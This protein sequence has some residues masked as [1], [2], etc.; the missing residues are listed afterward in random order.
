MNICD[1]VYFADV[2]WLHTTDYLKWIRHF[3]RNLRKVLTEVWKDKKTKENMREI[4]EHEIS[5]TLHWGLGVMPKADNEIYVSIS[6]GK[7]I[8]TFHLLSV[9][10]QR[11]WFCWKYR[12]WGSHLKNRYL[13]KVVENTRINFSII[14]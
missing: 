13:C 12:K 3:A 8:V 7:C 14:P 6:V 5:N 9:L 11:K 4:K 10:Y 2:A 1:G